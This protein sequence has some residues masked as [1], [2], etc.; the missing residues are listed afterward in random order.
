MPL[1]MG[2]RHLERSA[3]PSADH[4]AAIFAAELGDAEKID[5][6][7]LSIENATR[8]L[9]SFLHHEF[10]NGTEVVKIIHGRGEQKL[11]NAVMKMLRN[12][13][14]V[15]YFRGSNSPTQINAVTYAALSR[16]C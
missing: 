9:D 8:E 6:H 10:M 2:E 14:V 16:K 11:Q 4:E 13:A 5:L 15:E 1:N 7:G 12:H 3:L